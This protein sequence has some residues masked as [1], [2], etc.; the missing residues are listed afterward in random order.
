M[1]DFWEQHH[2]PVLFRGVHILWAPAAEIS[3]AAAA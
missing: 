3:Q 1:M 2:G